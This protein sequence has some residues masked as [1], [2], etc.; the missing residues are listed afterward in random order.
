MSFLE[1]TLHEEIADNKVRSVSIVIQL[2]D[3]AGGELATYN[4]KRL[5]RPIRART[6]RSPDRLLP[7]DRL[8]LNALR[9]RVP[10][11]EQVTMPVRLKELMK[12]CEISRSQARICLKRLTEKGL[13]S[14]ISNGVNWGSQEGYPY[15]I[16]RNILQASSVVD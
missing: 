12:E 1:V 2:N 7:S 10:Q 14:R 16:S 4:N 15:K 3:Q 11:G 8:V 13:V 5:T 6:P 9:A